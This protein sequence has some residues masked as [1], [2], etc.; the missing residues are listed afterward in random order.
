MLT[1]YIGLHKT[2][3]M[4]GPVLRTSLDDV[5]HVIKFSNPYNMQPKPYKNVIHLIF[6][7]WVTGYPA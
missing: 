3:K 7:Y 1:G 2:L 6:L 5:S 4:Q